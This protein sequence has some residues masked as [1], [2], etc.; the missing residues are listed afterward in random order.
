[1][2]MNIS[3]IVFS[4]YYALVK[5]NLLE[6]C[7]F[8]D[9]VLKS[10][11]LL[12]NVKGLSILTRT[13]ERF[14]KVEHGEQ[15]TYLGFRLRWHKE[16][17]SSSCRSWQN[18]LSCR[19]TLSCSCRLRASMVRGAPSERK[20]VMASLSFLHSIKSFCNIITVEVKDRVLHAQQYEDIEL[21]Y[22][23]CVFHSIAAIILV[24][25]A[26]RGA[27]YHSFFVVVV[28][29]IVVVGG[30]SSGGGGGGGVVFVR[31]RSSSSSRPS[32]SDVVP[33]FFSSCCS[34]SVLVFFSVLST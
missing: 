19:F 14:K 8:D 23:G 29:I 27:I 17:L 12:R 21:K 28:V 25:I 3:S 33:S 34:S 26:C 16:A 32:S 15:Q 7:I 31:R 10:K 30:W 5:V 24:R 13:S 9:S 20:V 1:M 2:N 18:G 11:D 22:Y 6:R 4:I